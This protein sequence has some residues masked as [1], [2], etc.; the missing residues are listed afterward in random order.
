MSGE[1]GDAS[2]AR[3]RHCIRGTIC[4]KH[5]PIVKTPYPYAIKDRRAARESR[6]WSHEDAVFLAILI[7]ANVYVLPEKAPARKRPE[8]GVLSCRVAAV[9]TFLS[10][11]HEDR[12]RTSPGR[13]RVAHEHR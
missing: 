3:L 4:M 11:R 10:A 1:C 7:Q 12:T 6:E 13:A 2:R 8:R 9:Q 5:A